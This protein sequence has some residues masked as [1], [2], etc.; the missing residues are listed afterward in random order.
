MQLALERI[1]GSSNCPS[2]AQ[3]AIHLAEDFWQTKKKNKQ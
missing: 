1:Y 3:I 2:R